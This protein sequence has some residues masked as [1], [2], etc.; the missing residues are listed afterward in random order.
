[1]AKFEGG[2]ACGAVRYSTDAD[3]IMSGHCQ[4]RKCQQLSGTGHASFAAFPAPAV[5]VKGD[6]KFW[7]YKADSGNQASRGHCPT[8]GSMVLGKTSG[9]PDMIAVQLASLD[10]PSKITPQMVFYHAKAQPWDH[11]DS[12]LQSFPGMPPM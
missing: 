8:C 10:N 1:M 12:K 7:S 3:P 4:C 11:V 5:K 6:V 2:C 9:F